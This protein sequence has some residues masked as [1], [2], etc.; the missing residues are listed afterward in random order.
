MNMSETDNLVLQNFNEGVI[1]CEKPNAS[2]YTFAGN[3][4]FL[5]GKGDLTI[6]ID[7]S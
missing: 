4:R 5:E 2:I 6:P 3:L 1:E 7:I